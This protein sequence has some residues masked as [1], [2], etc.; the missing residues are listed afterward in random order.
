[1]SLDWIELWGSSSFSLLF[2][3]L[4]PHPLFLYFSSPPV[5]MPLPGAHC[6]PPNLAGGPGE[7]RE[8]PHQRVGGSGAR[9]HRKSICTGGQL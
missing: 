9:Y 6:P 3:F 2:P 1:M 8:L 5:L 7:G 4:F